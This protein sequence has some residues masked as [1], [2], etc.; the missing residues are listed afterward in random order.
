VITACGGSSEAPGNP[1][2]SAPRPLSLSYGEY[3]P[4]GAPVPYLAL[5]LK[6][7]ERAGQIVETSFDAFTGAGATADSECGIGGRRNGQIEIFYTPF[8]LRPGPQT[9]QITALGSACTE[10]KETRTAT[11]TFHIY[12]SRADAPSREPLDARGQPP[13]SRPF[14]G[15]VLAG[16]YPR[17]HAEGSGWRPR[18]WTGSG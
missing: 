3:Q 5:R 12:V 13:G 14:G 9:V 11:R 1:G 17:S 16:L 4:R 8:T 10:A 6:A 15:F 7:V 18:L 2:L